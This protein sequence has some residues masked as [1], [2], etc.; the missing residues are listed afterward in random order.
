MVRKPTAAST[1]KSVQLTDAV[2]RE[3][4]RKLER[5]LEELKALDLNEIMRNNDGHELDALRQKTNATLIEIYGYESLE[6]RDLEISL[7]PIIMSYFGDVDTSIR[8]NIDAVAKNINSSIRKISTQ[9]EILKEQVSVSSD[10]PAGRTIRAYEGLDLHKEIARAASKLYKDGHYASAVEHSVKALNA[11]VRLRSG[12][13]VD[14]SK[15]ME[16]AFGGKTPSIKFNDLA[17]QSDLDEQRGFMMLFSGAVAGLRNPR[18][19]GFI[20]DSPDRALEFI[21]FISLLAKILDEST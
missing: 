12:L 2:A 10:E 4:I 21:S 16:Q 1:T 8:G 9:I 13:E 11:L 19:H 5:R 3:A 18:A 17:D 7:R 15:L 20:E 6:Y 14:G